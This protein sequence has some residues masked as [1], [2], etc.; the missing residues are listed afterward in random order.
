MKYLVIPK[1]FFRDIR[2]DVKISDQSIIP[3]CFCDKCILHRFKQR[4]YLLALFKEK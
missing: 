1:D 3:L 4:Q 2:L